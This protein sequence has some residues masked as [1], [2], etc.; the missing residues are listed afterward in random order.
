MNKLITNKSGVFI[1]MPAY[2]EENKIAEAIKDLKNEG[3]YN[4]IV[5]DDGS[6]D[7][8]YTTALKEKVVVL[9]HAVNR[10]QGAA[11]KTGIEFALKKGADIIV[12]FDS[13]GQHK[14]E[15]IKNLAMPVINREVDATLGSRFLKENDV[16]PI[17]RMFLRGGAFI[18]RIF[19]GIKLTDTHNG[20]RALSRHACQRI[21]LKSDKM[22]HASEILEEI[23]TKKISFKEIP[24]TIKYTHYSIN[25][26]QST[27]NAFKILYKMML[28]K[29]LR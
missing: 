3:Y 12:T 6:K 29:F 4:I 25:H 9:K 15:D 13:D 27:L 19:Y 21:R 23:H 20:I 24:V 16:P 14:A 5:V 8:T 7:S 1:V 10:G 26:G 22:E 18:I 2:N 28:N 17:R 11:L